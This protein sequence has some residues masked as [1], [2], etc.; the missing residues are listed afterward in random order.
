[1]TR[2]DYKEVAKIFQNFKKR[3]RKDDW[4]LLV[5]DFAA[6][7]QTYHPKFDAQRFIAS[8]GVTSEDV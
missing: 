2:R 6:G 5:N 7:L 4:I 8:C 3:I 1:M